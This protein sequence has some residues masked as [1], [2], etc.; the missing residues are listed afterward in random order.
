M[1]QFRPGRM[2]N[3]IQ[4]EI[5][6]II[7]NEVKDPRIGMVSVLSV[8][9]SRDLGSAK[10]HF[11]TF[12]TDKKATLAALE[13]AKG[14]IRHALGRRIQARVVPELFFYL[15]DSIAYGIRMAGIIDRQI[16]KDKEAAKQE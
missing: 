6:D 10:V 4:K 2:A 8:E 14:F 15:D 12:D 16:Q 5:A 1:T 9:V 11:S 13:S 3:E 7:A